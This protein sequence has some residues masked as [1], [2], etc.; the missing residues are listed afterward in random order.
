[1][2]SKAF[3]RRSVVGAWSDMPEKTCPR[4][5]L[6][7]EARQLTCHFCGT[8]LV[9]GQ[10]RRFGLIVFTTMLV[11]LVALFAA[12]WFSLHRSGRPPV[13]ESGA[14]RR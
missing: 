2:Q 1:V 4:C 9:S 3:S 11:L 13:A 6:A 8:S 7:L 5:G 14:V 10:S 12:Q